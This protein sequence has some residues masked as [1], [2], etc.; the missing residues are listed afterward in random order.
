VETVTAKLA[1]PE[2]EVDLRGCSHGDRHNT[3]M[4]ASAECY[5]SRRRS[6]RA[7]E[8]DPESGRRS[9]R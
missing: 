4:L 8:P 7:P 2:V 9:S 6:G 3:T 5:W 1:D